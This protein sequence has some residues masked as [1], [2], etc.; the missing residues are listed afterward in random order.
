MKSIT[1]VAGKESAWDERP[2][3]DVVF[4]DAGAREGELFLHPSKCEPGKGSFFKNDG[5]R[6]EVR[7]DLGAHVDYYFLPFPFVMP[8]NDFT[9]AEIHLFEPNPE[10]WDQLKLVVSKI[11]HCVASITIHQ[12]AVWTE[13]AKRWLYL[14]PGG[15]GSSLCSNKLH[16]EFDGLEIVDCIDF[17]E[18]IRDL[19]TNEVHI[20]MDVEGAE[21]DILNNLLTEANVDVFDCVHSLSVEFHPDAFPSKDKEFWYQHATDIISLIKTNHQ[22]NWWP[23]EW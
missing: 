21:Y 12:A 1:Y 4:I 8:R 2:T 11:S 5:I 14:T 6:L 19:N 7:E 23:G 20:K 17:A 13:N 10:F 16:E 18:F 9:G 22:I 15:W 3:S